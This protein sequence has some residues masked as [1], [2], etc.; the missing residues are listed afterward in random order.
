MKILCLHGFM[1]TKNDFDFLKSHHD[2]VAIDLDKLIHLNLEDIWS[3]IKDSYDLIIGY[4]FG[5]RLALRLKFECELDIPVLCL[6]GHAGLEEDEL[7]DRVT[8]EEGFLEKIK[9]LDDNMFI[10]YWN[11][12]GLFK[13]DKKLNLTA[14]PSKETRSLYFTNYGLSKQPNFHD[15]LYHENIHFVYGDLDEKYKTYALTKLKQHKLTFIKNCGHRVIIEHDFIL[16]YIGD[17]FGY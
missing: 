2:I 9:T 17:Y 11:S 7:P 8:I 12:L 3:E 10:D 14:I 1:G 15:E 4:S 5:A 16:K 6:A 13:F